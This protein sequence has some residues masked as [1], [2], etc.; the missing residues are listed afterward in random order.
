MKCLAFVL[1]LASVF[2]FA[3]TTPAQSSNVLVLEDGTPIR[4][5]LGRTLSSEDAHVGDRVDFE[6]LEEVSIHDLLIIR[7]GA[8]ALATITAKKE[9][10][11]GGS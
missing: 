4:L 10:P 7:K 11:A 8:L 6:V 9:W 3:Q 5:R 1:V 2:A